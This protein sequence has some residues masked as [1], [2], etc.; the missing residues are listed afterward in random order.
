[1]DKKKI[2]IYN[3]FFTA[4]FNLKKMTDPSFLLTR[5]EILNIYE[6]IRP[7]AGMN[8]APL[9]KEER[10]YF[11]KNIESNYSV[12]QEE[13]SVILGDYE[14]D[15]EWFNEL[16]KSDGYEAYFWQRYR[17]F[18]RKQK[19][20]P[21]RVLDNLE[22]NTLKNLMSYIGNPNQDARFSIRGLVVGDVQSGKTSNYIGL[23]TK[24]AD[25]GY[26]VIF[27]L[28][29]TIE[30]LRKQTQQRIEEGFIGYD[31]LNG[32][33]VGVG[34]GKILPISYTS[35][36][37]DFTGTD[38]LNTSYKITDSKEPVVFVVKKNLSVLKKIFSTLKKINTHFEGEKINR[39][40]LMID[41]E[42]DNAS[43]N[44]NKK[45]EDPTKI[46]EMIRKILSLFEKT[47]YIGFTATPFANVFINY[48]TED[49][50]L[51]NDLFPRD[52]IYSLESPSNYC[53]SRK[54]FVEHNNALK[55]IEDFDEEIFPLS[56]PKDWDG[57]KLFPSLY[58]AIN[59]FLLTNA[60]RDIRDIDINTHRSML[61]NMS[62]FTNVQL[63]IKEI[64]EQY[65]KEIKN[66]IKLTYRYP[67]RDYVYT[68]P[69]ILAL[70]NTYE[71]EFKDVELKSNITWDKVY[72]SLY[73]SIK[74]IKII[75]VNS[76][77]NSE[78]LIYGDE[79][80][81]I[82]AIGGIALSRGLT[83]EGL[84][85][86]YFY[87]NTCT[88]DVLMQMGRWFGYRNNY[89][90][91]C[92]IY[93]TETTKENYKEICFDIEYLKAD[94]R[95]MCL[96]KKQPKDYGIRVKNESEEL[97]ITAPNK[98]RNTTNKIIRKNY[99]GNVFETPY[100]HTDFNIINHN[101]IV[102]NDFINKI[103]L[104]CRDFNITQHPYYRNI[105]F[106]NVLDLLEN[107][108]IHE[109]NVNFDTKQIIKFL[110]TYKHL[111]YA[112]DVLIMGGSSDK[113]FFNSH[114]NCKNKLVLRNCDIKNKEE[115]YVIRVSESRAKL[116]GRSDT[117]YGLSEEKYQQ[118]EG[119][120]RSRNLNL[121][122]AKSTDFMVA[123]R[124]PL[125]IIYPLDIQ[126]NI[127]KDKNTNSKV[128]K[129]KM[130]ELS[131]KMQANS[132]EYMFGFGIGFPRN[133]AIQGE[134]M[135][136]TVNKTVSYYDMEH[137]EEVDDE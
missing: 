1:M 16:E 88:F 123:G 118:L 39:S 54:Y 127:Y 114:L 117:M 99:F 27:V 37:K 29:G 65:F 56:H 32:V 36:A 126:I 45:D 74:N 55:Y 135:I 47:S 67:N 12:Y 130:I 23:I 68:N 102:T 6:E 30:S 87:R 83:L 122:S 13:G 81:R 33:D 18:L 129:E 89:E 59:V 116:M 128:S 98:M 125:L 90:D 97:R 44:T 61:I 14:H 136:Y 80:N 113:Y 105:P 5:E 28:T 43:I 119:E 133:E 120:F 40:L 78:K 103:P 25:A 132:F 4:K 42:A 93:L 91:L 22:N 107:L 7:F 51:G 106:E 50:M 121:D 3:D 82:I 95:K 21:P 84:T 71:A 2:S 96:L 53:G 77:K 57:E 66:D 9:S 131:N 85:T 20:F 86:S 34:R 41:D 48:N 108:K 72:D 112:F 63:K 35:R 134:T 38:Y 104:N 101:I 94:I 124:N 69:N 49:E 15:Y 8:L 137:E 92:R 10:E 73:E 26:K 52:F 100:L 46:N 75:V 58:E 62:R 60:I 115:D 70:K 109:A 11:L 111:L 79:G 17:D 31:S 19:N 24:A 76:S 110:S 64:V